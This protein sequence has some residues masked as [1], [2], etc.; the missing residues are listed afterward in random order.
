VLITALTWGPDTC[1][2]KCVVI[3]LDGHG[4]FYVVCRPIDLM[5]NV[6]YKVPLLHKLPLPFRDSMLADVSARA[7]WSMRTTIGS[8]REGR[9][10]TLQEGPFPAQRALRHCILHRRHRRET[11]FTAYNEIG[12]PAYQRWSRKGGCLAKTLHIKPLSRMWNTFY[13]LH[14]N[15]ATCLPEMEDGR[16]RLLLGFWDSAY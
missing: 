15:R 9:E 13:S 1:A 11:L 2:C 16:G 14:R 5:Y 12:P 7:S 8:V 3:Q 6:Q 10:V 4:I